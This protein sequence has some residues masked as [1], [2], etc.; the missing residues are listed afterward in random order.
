MVA[1]DHCCSRT[2]TAFHNV[3]VEGSLDEELHLAAAVER[4]R[5]H[6]GGSLLEGSNELATNNFA[7][8][9]GVAHACKRLEELGFRIDG[10]QANTRGGHEVFLHLFALALS[11]Q[12]VVDKD[13][14]QLVTDRF[15]NKCGCHR[16]IHAARE[17][18][19]DPGI[20]HLCAY[21]VDLCGND[22]SAVPVVG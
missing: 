13:T 19:D 8:G 7:L 20:P 14:H 10:H 18:A 1:L 15:V 12:A 17:P 11:E 9:L 4:L 16:R 6:I 2:A 3:R 22:V 5:H 21:G